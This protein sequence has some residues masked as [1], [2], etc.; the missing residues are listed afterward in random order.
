MTALVLWGPGRA[1]PAIGAKI[2]GLPV[3][4]TTTLAVRLQTSRRFL[5]YDDDLAIHD[6]K[7]ELPGL[8][9]EPWRGSTDETGVAEVSIATAE[10]LPKLVPVR[11]TR[12]REVL[13]EGEITAGPPI[14]MDPP[15][16]QVI[17]GATTGPLQIEVDLPRGHLVSPFP[18]EMRITVSR[19]GQPARAKISPRAPGA[20]IH[21]A[22]VMTDAEGQA[23]LEVK[24]LA[25]ALDLE[26]D[27]LA[28][29][30][31]SRGHWEGKVP[32]DHGAVFLEPV[33]ASEGQAVLQLRSTRPDGTVYASI[34]SEKGRIQGLSVPIAER[35]G[36]GVGSATVRLP[37]SEW[38]MV[39]TG[40]DPF[41]QSDATVAW[42]LRPP[43]GV[44]S[45]PRLAVLV[46]GMPQAEQRERG[47][48]WV[49]KR[50]AIL[51]IAAAAFAEALLLIYRSRRAQRALDEHLRRAAG[52]DEADALSLEDR[53][54]LLHAGNQVG[55]ILVGLFV[56]LVV[57][58]FAI[59]ATLNLF[60]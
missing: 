58:G 48:A 45:P 20:E 17:G 27:A 57:F 2:W 32:L 15:S 4:G 8:A 22:E 14:R 3:E 41:E 59:V 50:S 31:P 52:S 1:Q 56:A 44:A 35:G 18:S 49:A 28:E 16:R 25:L 37:P 6:L 34:V 53:D 33:V 51:V 42:P 12:G 29:G 39:I 21:P 19:D 26:I 38:L 5:G 11:L 9:A 47:R 55:G 43:E 54:K 60:R 13:L 30:D 46:D 7:L 36:F 10:P 23:R 40:T 24:A